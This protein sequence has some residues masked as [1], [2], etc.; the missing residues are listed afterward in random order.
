MGP[1]DVGLA[2]TRELLEQSAAN[3]RQAVVHTLARS[4]H[5]GARPLLTALAADPNESV[6]RL[7]ARYL[8]E[9]SGTDRK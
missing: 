2:T 6:R 4:R 3:L 5:P 7:A 8:A 1:D 9:Q